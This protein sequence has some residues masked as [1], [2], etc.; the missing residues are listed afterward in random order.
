MRPI[1]RNLYIYIKKG[2]K[3][4]HRISVN[5]EREK[6]HTGRGWPFKRETFRLVS[7]MCVSVCV[8][9]LKKK[10]RKGKK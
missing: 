1:E 9:V 2:G 4:A 7:R 8:C 10:K 5:E 3:K 6:N